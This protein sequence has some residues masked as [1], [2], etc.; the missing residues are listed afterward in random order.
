MEDFISSSPPERAGV[1]CGRESIVL[2]C[3]VMRSSYAREGE[4]KH[5]APAVW[6][7]R[8]RINGPRRPRA[9][10]TAAAAAGC[11][12]AAHSQAHFICSLVE[13]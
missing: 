12:R 13:R 7:A 6:R 1:P 10:W 9:S 5:V 4:G 8:P 2:S 11:C 3:G